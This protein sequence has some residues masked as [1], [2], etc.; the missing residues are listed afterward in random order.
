M[1]IRRV[2]A[3]AALLAA[4]FALAPR[5]T[6]QAV[7][8]PVATDDST[9]EVLGRVFPDPHGCLSGAPAASPWAKGNVCAAQFVQWDE[10]LAGLRY[11]EER[12]GRFIELINL[13][14]LR[15]LEPAFANL[16]MQSA[17]LPN[18]DLS[19]DRRDLYAVRVTDRQSPVPE[20]ERKH[21]VYGLSIHGIERAGLEGGIRAAE[22]L[23][24]WAAESPDQP[25]LEPSNS[26]PTAGQVAENA[27]VYFVLANPD[28]WHRGEVTN[29]R[30]FFQRYNGNGMDINRDWAAV[31]YTQPEYTPFS[32]PETRGYSAYLKGLASKTSAGKFAGGID[33]H[34][35]VTSHSFSFTLLGAGQRDYRKNAISVDTAIKTFRDAEERLTWSPHLARADS[36]P[37]PLP[38]PFFG[39]TQG[40]MCTDQWGTVWDTINY[41]VAGSMGDWIDSPLGLDGVGMNNEMALSHLFPNTVFDPQIEQLH[42]DGNKGLVYSQIASLLFEQSVEYRPTGRIGYVPNPARVTNPGKPEASDPTAALPAQDAIEGTEVGGAGFEFEVQG[43]EKGVRNGSLTVEATWTNVRGISP[44]GFFEDFGG[45][46]T[47]LVLER[48]GGEHAGDPE[49]W[50]EVA[51]YFNQAGSYAQAGA[52]IDLNDPKPGRYRIR[53]A[54]RL[55]PMAVRV[56]FGSGRSIPVPAQAPYDVANTDFFPELNKYVPEGSKLEAIDSRQVLR[57]PAALDRLDTLVLAGDGAPG[58]PA[59]RRQ[60]WFEAVRRFAERGGNVVLT[61]GALGALADIGLVPREAV[62]QGVFFAGWMNFADSEGP[63]Y[64]RHPLAAGVDKEGTAEGQATLDDVDYFNRHQLYEPVPLGYY[65]SPGG[66]SNADC[67][68]NGDRCDSPNW[69]V[70]DEAW[71]KAGGDIAARTFVREAEE[72]G[73]SGF[74]GVSLGELR[75]GAGRIRIVGALLPPPTEKNYHPFGLASYA[76]TYT[77]Y[78]V[79]ENAVNYQRPAAAAPAPA[80]VPTEVKGAGATQQDDQ[81]PATGGGA[82]SG[83]VGAGAF[84]AWLIVRRRILGAPSGI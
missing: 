32:E 4:A 65:V 36:C 15:D 58:I 27:V 26:G 37:G 34:G 28:G 3:I 81:I 10:A 35:M 7:A 38:E 61:D 75:L 56:T 74:S 59:E 77:G 46:D 22:D 23:V 24:T 49:E 78:Q 52:R 51:R 6:P 18:E 71:T 45:D 57:N 67:S 80:A 60:A 83:W 5:S 31:G 73:S 70:A 79:F 84:A 11:L 13:R 50:I 55:A 54:M 68:A 2:L 20:R 48:F 43:S 76:L 41:Q 53:P 21:F 17:G 19:R 63:T 40:P 9:Y 39:R 8:V 29:G 14:E 82:V 66:A 62:R 33:L 1:H 72:A 12:Y 25:I 16:D 69:V 64:G 42:I 30:V 44:D 47:A